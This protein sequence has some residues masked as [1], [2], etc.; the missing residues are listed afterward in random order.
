MTWRFYITKMSSFEDIKEFFTGQKKTFFSR[1][2]LWR[3]ISFMA[4]KNAK[5]HVF[6]LFDLLFVDIR[7]PLCTLY[8]LF[9]YFF[10]S[11]LISKQNL[12]TSAIYA[13]VHYY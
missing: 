8:V 11:T 12:L 13:A 3:A 9:M 1:G 2:V 4:N 6:F 7:Y 10:D 5:A